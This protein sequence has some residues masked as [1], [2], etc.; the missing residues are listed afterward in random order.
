MLWVIP[1][2]HRRAFSIV[3]NTTRTLD[4]VSALLVVA[5]NDNSPTSYV[6][7]VMD[8]CIVDGEPSWPIYLLE[9]LLP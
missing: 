5:S 9:K 7:L 6:M 2:K 8:N 1:S 4:I 3:G